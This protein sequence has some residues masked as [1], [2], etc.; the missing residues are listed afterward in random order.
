MNN[1][2][3]DQ[4]QEE[5]KLF[6][7]FNKINSVHLSDEEYTQYLENRADRFSHM[8]IEAHL[9]RCYF[10]RG[11]LQMLKEYRSEGPGKVDPII[12]DRVNRLLPYIPF[13]PHTPVRKEKHI[14]SAMM[15]RLIAHIDY[16]ILAAG[17]AGDSE[18]D[19]EELEYDENGQYFLTHR[20]DAQGDLVYKIT[21]LVEGYVTVI[22][23]GAGQ[24][25]EQPLKPEGD[26]QWT[27]TIIIRSKER[28]QFMRYIRSGD[29]AKLKIVKKS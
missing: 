21:V 2:I 7:F 17:V 9:E 18:T 12:A 22:L 11:E 26:D 25:W 6:E 24:E 14:V 1:K 4:E 28:E 23:E 16:G 3:N 10:C 5:V 27:A 13:H 8:R 15:E 19:W 29:S 20:I